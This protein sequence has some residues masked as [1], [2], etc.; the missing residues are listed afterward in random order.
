MFVT[1]SILFLIFKIS[2]SRLFTIIKNLF[3]LVL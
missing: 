2:Y 3:S 1:G